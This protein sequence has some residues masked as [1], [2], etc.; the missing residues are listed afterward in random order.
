VKKR[1]SAKAEE[2]AVATPRDLKRPL[3]S[4]AV[5]GA[6]FTV[7]A[8]VFGSARAGFSTGAGALIAFANLYVLGRVVGGAGKGA[9]RLIGVF[10]MV[11][12]F[13]GVW[14]LL[15]TGL[16]DPIPL[17]AGLLALPV[18]LVTGSM[19]SAGR[20]RDAP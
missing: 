10:K 14:L 5:T 8:F 15:T 18:G 2:G 1:R 16:V 3:V 17:V 9:W 6:V 12:L 7:L 4:V 13:A 11:A 19:L 20:A